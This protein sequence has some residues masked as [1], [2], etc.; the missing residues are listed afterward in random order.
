M[1]DVR[2]RVATALVG[3]LATLTSCTSTSTNAIEITSAMVTSVSSSSQETPRYSKVIALANGSA[4]IIDSMGFKDILVGRDI[5]STDES[6]KS[7]PIVST[8]H[9]LVAEKI[10]ALQPEL[11]IIDE[12]VG[13]IDAIET[14][15]STG[16]KVELINEVWSVGEISTK[17]GAIAELIG[18]PLAGQLLA[19]QVQLTISESAKAVS[20]SPRIAFLYLRGG[21]SIYLL[22]GKGS[23]ADSLITALGGVDVGAAISDTPFSAFSSESFANEDPEILLVMSK[24]LE[25]VGGVDGLITL[26]GVAQTRAG[27]NRAVIAVDD[28]LLLSF[29]P[30]TPNLL[31][32]LADAIGRVKR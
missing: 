3:L 21:N 11:V 18:T 14:I 28:S 25:S 19:D 6:L 7:V 5:A 20:G 16:I 13:P 29:G 26:P 2:I 30:R 27:K 1:L 10:I 4:E 32:E 8:G 24:G 15:R 31:A 12:S 9:Q 17:V 23:G 22:G